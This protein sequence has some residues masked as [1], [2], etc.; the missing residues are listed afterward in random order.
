MLRRSRVCIDYVHYMNVK[1]PGVQIVFQFDANERGFTVRDVWGRIFE[2]KYQLYS[3]TTGMFARPFGYEVNMSSSDRESPESGRMSQTLM[4][5]ERDLG[6]M[7]EFDAR[8]K[9]HSL[10]YLKFDV[11]FFNGQGINASGDFDNKK[12]LITRLA[13]KPF[14]VTDKITLS[15]GTSLLYSGLLQNTKYVYSTED[16]GGVKSPI[17]DSSITNVGQYSPRQYNGIDAQLKINNKRGFTELRGEFLYGTQ[18]GT[19][20]SSETLIALATGTDGF[21]RRNF[22]GAYIYFLQSLFSVKHQLMLKYDWYD[23]NTMVK[24][25]EIGNGFSR[26]DIKYNALNMGYLFHISDQSKLV[27]FYAFVKNEA[28]IFPGFTEDLK[29]NILTCR[30]QFRF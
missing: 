5:S 24:G 15:A 27:L 30:I 1:G 8:R 28:T 14:P 10:R 25:K 16:I 11:G 17:V 19:K 26:A 29:D 3:F 4:K 9:G 7:I 21:Y 18:T 23:P 22:N 2:N 20:N 6:A 13:L 12:D